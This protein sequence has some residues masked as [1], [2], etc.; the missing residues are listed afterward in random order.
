MA[1]FY[2]FSILFFLSFMEACTKTVA[3]NS[4][5]N[6][7]TA[8]LW[9]MKAGNSWVYTDSIFTADGELSTSYADSTFISNKTASADGNTFYAYNDSLGWFGASGYVAADA[10]NSSLYVLDSLN[11]GS[12]Y[13]I[14]SLSAPT[15][16][17]T[18]YD[19]LYSFTNTFI[20]NGYSCYKNLEQEKDENGNVVYANVY[21]VSPG[22]GLVR[23]EEYS[24]SPNT[25][26]LFRDYSQT[27]RSFNLK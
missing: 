11:A 16:S 1:R 25:N 20:V 12:S 14:F 7:V 4:A 24:I 23:I 19:A 6:I 15:P 27:L 13:L 22:V 9:P 2:L 3:D 8:P 21:Y 10:T 17:A 18:D 26:S 5:G